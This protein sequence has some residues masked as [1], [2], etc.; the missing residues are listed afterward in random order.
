M[1]FTD[2]TLPKFIV[3]CFHLMVIPKEEFVKGR[4]FFL[5]G[6]YSLDFLFLLEGGAI[7]DAYKPPHGELRY[8]KIFACQNL[9]RIEEKKTFHPCVLSVIPY[10]SCNAK[11]PSTTAACTLISLEASRLPVL[12]LFGYSVQIG[13]LQV[14]CARFPT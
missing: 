4:I 14:G 10:S 1:E 8:A 5:P 13:A 7:L 3:L 6:S 9:L 12:F 11:M 2:G